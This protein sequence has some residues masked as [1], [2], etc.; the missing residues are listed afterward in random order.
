MEQSELLRQ[1]VSTLE[2][3]GKTEVWEEVLKPTS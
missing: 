2:R 1:V 3:M